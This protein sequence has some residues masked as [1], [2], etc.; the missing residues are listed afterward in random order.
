[1]FASVG[2]EPHISHLL[3]RSGLAYLYFAGLP[4][5]Y[6]AAT[7]LS[8]PHATER[9]I[10]LGEWGPRT[11]EGCCVRA[12]CLSVVTNVHKRRKIFHLPGGCL[13]H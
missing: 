5:Y 11:A 6:C 12:C 9:A 13:D 8:P 7:V 4:S 2:I 1:M 10:V 3:G